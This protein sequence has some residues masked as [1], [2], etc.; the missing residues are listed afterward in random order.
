MSPALAAAAKHDG[1]NA[2]ESGG[3]AGRDGTERAPHQH[4]RYEKFIRNR[5]DEV[6]DVPRQCS[7]LYCFPMVTPCIS[8]RGLGA[9]AARPSQPWLLQQSPSRCTGRASPSS[10]AAPPQPLHS[11]HQAT[12][13]LGRRS[14]GGWAG[15]GCRLRGGSG[16]VAAGTAGPSLTAGAAPCRA[17]AGLAAGPRLESLMG[18][19]VVQHDRRPPPRPAPQSPCPDRGWPHALTEVAMPKGAMRYGSG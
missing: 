4:P 18:L 17:L 10:P 15:L 11:H 19:Q 6:R 2:D 1:D 9:V 13:W 7:P 8:Q 16:A 3:G 5:K 12:A 14:A